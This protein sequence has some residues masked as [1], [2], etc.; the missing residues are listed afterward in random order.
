MHG[1]NIK[2]FTLLEVLIVALILGVLLTLAVPQFLN[3]R[4][5][6][7]QKTCRSNLRLINGAKDQFA[8]AASRGAGDPVALTDVAPDYLRKFPSCPGGGSYT[9]NTVGTAARCSDEFGQYPH[10]L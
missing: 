1:R 10:K 8:L 3:S 5:S 6:S 7:W 9:I 4:A 2:A